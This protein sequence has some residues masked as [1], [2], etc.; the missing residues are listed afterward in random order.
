MPAHAA[1]GRGAFIRSLLAAAGKA[2]LAVGVVAGITAA[3]AFTGT[4][5]TPPGDGPA[6]RAPDEVSGDADR[7]AGPAGVADPG[8]D[9]ASGEDPAGQD[10]A[11]QEPPVDDDPVVGSP[12][13]TPAGSQTPPPGAEQPAATEQPAG[14]SGQPAETEQPA[15]TQLAVQVLDGGAGAAVT[16]EV[17]AVLASYGYDVVAVRT[18]RCCYEVTTVLHNPGHEAAA[19][20]LRERDPRFARVDAN[21][22][23]SQAV[24]FHVV[25]GRDWGG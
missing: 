3:V 17:A 16:G 24:A 9:R 7:P 2:L 12:A 8:A 19:L 13:P 21:P 23:L 4:A 6:M 14:Q 1:E 25:V 10:P 18:A 11:G 15:A 5:G 22:N 20:A